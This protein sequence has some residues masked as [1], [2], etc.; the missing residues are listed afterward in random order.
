MIINDTIFNVDLLSIITTLKFQ[1]DENKI[2]LLYKFFESGDDVMVCCPFHKD[3]QERRPSAGIRK[4]DG[5]FHCLA[6][7]ETH[8]LP[9]VISY[10]LGFNDPFGREGYKWLCRNFSSVEVENRE[11]IQIDMERSSI[12]NKSNLLVNCNHSKL[13]CVSE[14]ELDSYRYTHPYMYKRGLNDSIIELFDIGYDRRTD[15]ITF[16]VRYWGSINFGSVLFVARRSV[17]NKRFDIPRGIEKPLYG[18]YEL[19]AYLMDTFNVNGVDTVYVCEGLF[20]CLRLWSVGKFAV[21]GFGCLFSDY[22]ITLLEGLPTRKLILATDNDTAGLKAR[23]R[24]RSTIKGKL[25]TEVELPNGRKDIGE[26][27]DDE[28]LHLNEVF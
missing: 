8:S 17:S 25:I 10:C 7:G 20:D 19:Y 23:D 13:L 14:E 21:A 6:C 3:G 2:P 11:S 9:E 16:P 12:S 18:L 5:L 27:A 22:Q 4:S 28:L 24:L 1:L 26:C 15:S